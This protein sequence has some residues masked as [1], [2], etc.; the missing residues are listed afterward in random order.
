MIPGLLAGNIFN[1]GSNFNFL[2]KVIIGLI[3]TAVCLF[4][5]SFCTNEIRSSGSKELHNQLLTEYIHE[6]NDILKETREELEDIKEKRKDDNED[7]KKREENNNLELSNLASK[8]LKIEEENL[9][10]KDSNIEL[11]ED[12]SSLKGK[13]RNY[14]GYIENLQSLVSSRNKEDN[15]NFCSINCTIREELVEFIKDN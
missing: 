13:V 15:S 14:I 8:I 9:K 4:S 2:S 6:R 5:I 3:I 10:L 7:S 11:E 1:A 12:N